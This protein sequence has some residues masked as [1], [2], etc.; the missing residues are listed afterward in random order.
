MLFQHHRTNQIKQLPL[1]SSISIQKLKSIP[2]QLCSCT[3]KKDIT[4]KSTSTLLFR[5]QRRCLIQINSILKK[6]FN[7]TLLLNSIQKKMSNSALL[8]SASIPTKRLNYLLV[9]AATLKLFL[10]RM[11]IAS[12][13]FGSTL[14]VACK[15]DFKK[16]RPSIFAYKTSRRCFIET[17]WTFIQSIR[18]KKMKPLRLL[19]D[20]LFQILPQIDELLAH[21]VL[22][23]AK[24][25]LFHFL[26]WQTQKSPKNRSSEGNLI[27]LTRLLLGV[28]TFVHNLQVLEREKESTPFFSIIF[29]DQRKKCNK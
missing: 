2:T 25:H 3:S 11:R 1:Y 27:S 21:F 4:F 18:R 23:F 12:T 15:I 5:L 28:T 26:Q 10:L 6:V 24:L 7:S 17:K 13:I 22:I 9:T 19:S 16:M 8:Q 20:I 14:A 29:A